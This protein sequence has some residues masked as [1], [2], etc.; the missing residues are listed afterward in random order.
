MHWSSTNC[1]TTRRFASPTK[2]LRRAVSTPVSA[3]DWRPV[4]PK[5]RVWRGPSGARTSDGVEPTPDEDGY[6]LVLPTPSTPT[7]DLDASIS[8][9]WRPGDAW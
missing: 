6:I 7:L 2:R 1:V 4:W 3:L 5:H 8:C 9:E